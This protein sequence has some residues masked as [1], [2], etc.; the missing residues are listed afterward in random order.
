MLALQSWLCL[1][2]SNSF[3][4]GTI[5]NAYF[6]DV[7]F[8]QQRT[9]YR[10]NDPRHFDC[11]SIILFHFRRLSLWL[12]KNRLNQIIHRLKLLIVLLPHAFHV[13]I[14]DFADLMFDWIDK[15][16]QK[17]WSFHMLWLL[18]VSRSFLWSS[19]RR[20]DSS[21]PRSSVRPNQIIASRILI[22]QRFYI[23]SVVRSCSSH[24]CKCKN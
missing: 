8:A 12:H 22:C 2:R 21:L 13:K 1:C 7:R 9:F 20:T 14:D 10:L 16:Y 4:F 15:Q 3:M 6:Q 18:C 5:Q 24:H 11:N 17:D 23:N 19:S